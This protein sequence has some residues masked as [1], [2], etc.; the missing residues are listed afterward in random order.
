MNQT[1]QPK[2]HIIA[3]RLGE[4]LLAIASLAIVIFTIY[5]NFNY[6]R[7]P[8]ESIK[9]VLLI[10]SNGTWI[11]AILLWRSIGLLIASRSKGME[12]MFDLKKEH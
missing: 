2:Q 8:Q 9:Y 4:I 5:V 6:D 10:V 12:N 7:I 1:E 3:I 11:L